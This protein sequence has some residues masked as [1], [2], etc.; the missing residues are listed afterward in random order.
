[1]FPSNPGKK[2]KLGAKPF[3]DFTQIDLM[4]RDG[5]APP[6]NPHEIL[7][8]NIISTLNASNQ[9]APPSVQPTPVQPDTPVI[10]FPPPEALKSKHHTYTRH[11]QNFS[12]LF[13]FC[14]QF[15]VQLN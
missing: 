5:I 13:L 11:K 1:M 4:F 14:K 7:Q 3:T 9:P 12:F 8:F 2:D 15:S 10:K 6:S